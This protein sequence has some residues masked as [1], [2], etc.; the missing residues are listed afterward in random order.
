[1][2]S[3]PSSRLR[4]AVA[5]WQIPEPLMVEKRYYFTH[6]PPPMID[7]TLEKLGY[8]KHEPF[9][10]KFEYATIQE[11]AQLADAEIQ[12]DTQKRYDSR[13]LIHPKRCVRYLDKYAL[14]FHTVMREF[15]T[16][17]KEGRPH[18]NLQEG[19]GVTTEPKAL[20]FNLGTDTDTQRFGDDVV[21]LH[22]FLKDTKTNWKVDL[23]KGEHV[24][25]WESFLNKSCLQLDPDSTPAPHSHIYPLYGPNH[26]K[27]VF[28]YPISS[29]SD[30][31]LQLLENLHKLCT[32]RDQFRVTLKKNPAFVKALAQY[33]GWPSELIK[34]RSIALN[35]VYND[36]FK[37]GIY[38]KKIGHTTVV[39]E[40]SIVI[41][42]H[43]CVKHRR[44][45]AQVYNNIHGTRLRRLDPSQVLA[46]LYS[47]FPYLIENIYEAFHLALASGYY[48]PDF[49]VAQILTG[50]I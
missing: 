11:Y 31:K 40:A 5:N 47:I 38:T 6:V 2:A 16:C 41:F 13:F 44:V 48:H 10:G 36:G 35:K 14:I 20:F 50:S 24:R 30:E 46:E 32:S 19:I 49:S 26:V 9:V 23:E 29:N 1:M 25:R 3:N 43:N 15:S 21:A 17:T 8:I 39:C 33:K 27:L 18:G 22:K 7:R 45:A 4:D 12:W 37:L 34:G 42:A 28:Y